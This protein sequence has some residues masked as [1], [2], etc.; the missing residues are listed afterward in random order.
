MHT[1]INKPLNNSTYTHQT[2]QRTI[3]LDITTELNDLYIT[4][5]AANKLDLAFR[6]L[7]YIAKMKP[8]KVSVDILSAED[9]ATMITECETQ[10]PVEP[11]IEP[12][13]TATCADQPPLLVMSSPRKQGSKIKN[14]ENVQPLTHAQNPMTTQLDSPP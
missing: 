10:I 11:N 7:A 1:N 4:A 6:I 2:N 8:E 12:T 13:T 3:F 14:E 5:K 9:M